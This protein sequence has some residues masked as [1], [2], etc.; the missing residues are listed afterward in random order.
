MMRAMQA[1]FSYGSPFSDYGDDISADAL[2]SGVDSDFVYDTDGY[3]NI[4][5]YLYN[6]DD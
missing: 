3:L 6:K 1:G 4:Y 2:M 5:T